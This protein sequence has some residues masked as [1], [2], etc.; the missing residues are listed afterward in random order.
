MIQTKLIKLFKE[1]NVILKSKMANEYGIHEST[2]RKAVERGTF[3]NFLE[4]FIF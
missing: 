3:K 4:A 2:L 1:Q